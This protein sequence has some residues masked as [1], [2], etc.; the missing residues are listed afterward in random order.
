M[1][2]E[3]DVMAITSGKDTGDMLYQTITG[4]KEALAIAQPSLP[5]KDDQQQPGEVIFEAPTD[6]DGHINSQEIESEEET[7]ESEDSLIGSDEEG[8]LSE[9]EPKRPE[10]IKAA[11]KENK[12]K[13]KEEKREARKIKVPKALK[14]KK[15]LSRP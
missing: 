13:V 14:K 15:K 6:Q 1:H 8:S 12:K 5:R 9:N 2:A 3:E 7:D 11:R 4:L 10:D